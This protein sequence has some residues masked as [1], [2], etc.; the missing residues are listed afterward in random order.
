MGMAQNMQPKV[1]HLTGEI[2]RTNGKDMKRKLI[3]IRASQTP[4]NRYYP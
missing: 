4:I 2:W 3:G 1:D